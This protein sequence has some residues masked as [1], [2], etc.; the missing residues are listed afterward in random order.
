MIFLFTNKP[1]P[2]LWIAD[3]GAALPPPD[4][5]LTISTNFKLILCDV[6]SAATQ[7]FEKTNKQNL[8]ILDIYQKNNFSNFQ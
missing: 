6:N 7:I 4:R 8:R 3:F 2:T 5:L 1:S